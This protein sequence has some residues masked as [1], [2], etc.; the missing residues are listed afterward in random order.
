MG[1]GSDATRCE[2]AMRDPQYYVGN[3]VCRKT[4]TQ[5]KNKRIYREMVMVMVMMMMT[6]TGVMYKAAG[7]YNVC[8]KR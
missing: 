7:R 3:A 2:Y 8:A 5:Q 6:M 1:D 4:G